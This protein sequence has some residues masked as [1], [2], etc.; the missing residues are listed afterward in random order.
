M[1]ISSLLRRRDVSYK[2][3]SRLPLLSAKPAVIFPA[4][5]RNRRW[6]LQIFILPVEQR[7]VCEQLA[8]GRCAAEELLGWNRRPLNG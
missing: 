3:N 7:H 1:L 6:P 2:P 8:W 4:S 5:E